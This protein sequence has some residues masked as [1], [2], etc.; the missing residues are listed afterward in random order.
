MHLLRTVYLGYKNF[1]SKQI[2]MLPAMPQ[3]TL[4]VRRQ[5]SRVFP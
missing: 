3:D 1:A 5:S 2:N 4:G